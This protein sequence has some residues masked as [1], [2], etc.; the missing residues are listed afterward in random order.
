MVEISSLAPIFQFDGFYLPANA[1]LIVFLFQITSFCALGTIVELAVKHNI[2]SCSSRIIPPI[3][4]AFRTT[5]FTVQSSHA[6]GIDCGHKS[7]ECLD[8]Y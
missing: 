6:N 4:I 3:P 7:N 1:L 2:L 8:I 5:T